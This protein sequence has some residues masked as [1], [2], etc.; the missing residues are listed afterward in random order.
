MTQVK[1]SKDVG[2]YAKVKEWYEMIVQAGVRKYD[3]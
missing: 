2:E 1:H 3:C